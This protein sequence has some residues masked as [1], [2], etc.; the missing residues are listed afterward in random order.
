MRFLLTVLVLSAAACGG[1]STTPTSTPVHVDTIDAAG[2]AVPS[3]GVARPP[4]LIHGTADVSGGNVTFVFQFASGTLD[5][6][7]TRLTVQLDTDQ[8]IGTG[9][10]GTSGLGI[11]YV[12]DM[13]S[14]NNNQTQIQL[15][16]P[17][18]CAADGPCYSTVGV[19]TLTF[20]ADTMTTTVPLTMLGNASGRFNYRVVAYVSPQPIPITVADVMPDLTLAPAHVP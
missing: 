20:G 5:P 1:S 10:T 14:R 8:N 16:T 17:A 13:W 18:L 9:I 19:S 15:A 3:G 12:L 7:S 11:D 6:Q 2:D 4:D